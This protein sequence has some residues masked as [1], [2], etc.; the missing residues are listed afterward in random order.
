MLAIQPGR[1]DFVTEVKYYDKWLKEPDVGVALDPEWR[2]GEGQ[3]APEVFGNVTGDELDRTAAYLSAFV[4]AHDLP[5][6]VM[7][8]H[9]L[10][11]DIEVF[12]PG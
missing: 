4:K 1:S 3:F 6:K 8:Y 7:L 5:E 12:S 9:Q 2:L 11:V 10:R